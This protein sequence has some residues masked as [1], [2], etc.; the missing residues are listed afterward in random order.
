MSSKIFGRKLHQEKETIKKKLNV[1]ILK[2][3]K[4]Q[5]PSNTN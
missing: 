1:R 2:K 3:I 5:Q 4:I